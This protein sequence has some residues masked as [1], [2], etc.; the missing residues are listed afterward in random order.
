MSFVS[1][2]Q[3]LG[4]KTDPF[5]LFLALVKPYLFCLKNPLIS[6]ILPVDHPL[7]TNQ[8]L[9][10]WAKVKDPS[11][12]DECDQ[13]TIN[14]IHHHRE[15]HLRMLR[16]EMDGI[17]FPTAYKNHPFYKDIFKATPI[18]AIQTKTERKLWHQRLCHFSPS[19]IAQAHKYCA[20]TTP[21]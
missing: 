11:F 19:I 17:H 6:P 4:S 10:D 8:K 2:G 15:E 1:T 12:K 5:W 3:E 18:Q 20:Y 13:A 9:I 14:A 16:D 21:N 7:A